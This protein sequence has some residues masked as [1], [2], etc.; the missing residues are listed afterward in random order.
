MNRRH[1][2]QSSCALFIPFVLPTTVSCSQQ[3][4]VSLIPD[5]GPLKPAD[6]NGVMLAEGFSSRIIAHS[7]QAVVD[8]SDYL[9]HGAPDGGA[10][11][12]TDD[13]GWIYVSNSELNAQQGGVGAIEFSNRGKILRAYP[14]LEGTSRNCAGGATPWNSWLSCEEVD[15][16]R[17]WECDPYG[18]RQA[19]PLDA[20][21]RFAHEAA[22]VDTQRLHIYLTE[23][24]SDGGF[25]R[26]IPSKPF[27]N[28]PPDLSQ[29]TLQIAHVDPASQQVQWLK[30]PDPS[31]SSTATRYQLA[32]SSAFKGGE[33]IVY[34]N[35]IV[36]FATKG[37][38]RIWAYNTHT[39]TL[40]VIYDAATHPTPIL[41]GVDNITL[42][43]AGELIIAED[44]DDLQIIAITQDNRLVPIAQL[45][46]HN[47]SEVTGPAFSPDGKRL[48]FSSQRGTTGNSHDGVTFEI[49]G[50]FIA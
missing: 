32:D 48:Y 42:S 27:D 26:F 16:G 38:N 25:Y 35:G 2:L 31:A 50:P 23:D 15:R 29:G 44:G 12:P 30:V 36:S 28:Y 5:I 13:N 19:R 17:V 4:P 7:N 3:K 14:I 11:F 41:K 18:R 21:G 49:S 20:L 33:G 24:I 46:G 9:W 6:V 39:N 1:F 43:P 10:C 47:S 37:D 45:V 40:H 22:C 34:L 8:N